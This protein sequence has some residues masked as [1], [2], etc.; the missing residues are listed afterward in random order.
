MLNP[1][2]RVIEITG[3]LSNHS[4][5]RANGGSEIEAFRSISEV[6]DHC[7]SD[8]SE[9]ASLLASRLSRYSQ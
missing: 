6:N 5:M 1:V 4:I 7:G 3:P 8:L 2:C 9:E